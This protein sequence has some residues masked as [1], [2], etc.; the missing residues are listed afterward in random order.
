MNLFVVVVA[1]L[2]LTGVASADALRAVTEDGKSVILNGDGTWRYDAPAQGITKPPQ[3]SKLFKGTRVRYGLWTDESKWLLAKDKG[4]SPE[5]DYAF[6]HVTGDAY[7]MVI[8]ERLEVPMES[9]KAIALQNARNATKDVRVTKEEL[10]N[11]NGTQVLAMQ[12]EGTIQG[13]PF[14]FNG[15]Y[16]AG[17]RGTIQVITYT[18]RNLFDEYR[19]DM[20]NLLSGFFVE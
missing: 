2:L 3:A 16:Y 11:V 17:K 10:R 1:L 19:R 6:R 5:R 14:V 12:M 15:Y 18:G 8:A 20:E 7:A 9:L 13:I 4:D